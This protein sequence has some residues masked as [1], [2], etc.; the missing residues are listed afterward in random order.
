MITII[1]LHSKENKESDPELGREIFDNIN[2]V[3]TPFFTLP[4]GDPKRHPLFITKFFN[5]RP[6]HRWEINDTKIE[7]KEHD[8]LFIYIWLSP[9]DVSEDIYLP[10]T[11]KRKGLKSANSILYKGK[12]VIVEFGHINKC[13]KNSS[14]IRTN[15]RYPDNIQNGE[16]H[17]RRPAI[18]VKVDRRG[19]KV[20]PL[21]SQKPSNL[22]DNNLVFELSDE[23]KE[24]IG[25][26]TKKESYALCD[27]IQTVCISRILPPL[28]RVKGRN[29][30]LRNE[31]Y[32]A[33]LSKKDKK[34]LDTGLL[35]SISKSTL[36]IEAER[37]KKEN[38][39]LKNKLIDIEKNFDS[40]K[41]MYMYTTDSKSNKKDDVDVEIKNFQEDSK[42]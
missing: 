4:I 35:A 24:N 3:M 34:L 38:E 5:K 23:S 8:E 10:Q 12:I 20:I 31:E 9:I 15:K 7:S 13:I 32:R 6:E 16:M 39:E 11:L 2:Q 27:M 28:F 29:K 26:F 42:K 41:E 25:D 21:T 22:L 1:Y 30:F 17:K 40:L 37:I 36:Y 19:V 33:Q 14:E 18:V